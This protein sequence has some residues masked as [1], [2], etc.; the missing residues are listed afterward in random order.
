VLD[1]HAGPCDHVYK[2]SEAFLNDLELTGSPLLPDPFDYP[3]PPALEG[4]LLRNENSAGA[5]LMDALCVSRL[6]L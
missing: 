6:V 2:S 5:V 1:N 3:S 4:H